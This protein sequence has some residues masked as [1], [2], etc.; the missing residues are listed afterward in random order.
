[1]IEF[2]TAF[3]RGAFQFLVTVLAIPFLLPLVIMIW[4]SF[5]GQGWQANYGAVLSQPLLPRFFLNSAIIAAG[6]VVLTYVATM[7]AAFVFAKIRLPWKTLAFYIVLAALTLPPA[8]LMVPLFMTV[9]QLGLFDSYLAVILP[10]S[11]L[12]VPF[13]VLL[14]R[15][16]IAGLPDE[17]LEAARIDGCG[18]FTAFLLIILPLTGP[19]S[20]VIVVWTM[21][22]AWNEYMLPLLFMQD[23]S[24]QAITQLPQYFMSE[25]GADTTK[26]VTVSVVTC[27][28]VVLVYLLLQRFIERGLTAG[29]VK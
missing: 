19:I 3:G 10:L 9:Q 1:M 25:Y 20:A 8:V 5:Q 13:T 18:I 24:M 12:A 6:T 26:I 27:L 21:L 14:A 17:L 22:G 23:P 2:R 16:Y 7:L 28:P 11:A 15:T 4:L 29:A